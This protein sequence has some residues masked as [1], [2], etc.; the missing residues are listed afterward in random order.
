MYLPNDSRYE[1]SVTSLTYRKAGGSGLTL[2]AV[3]LGLWQNFGDDTALE[4]Q[5]QLLF[6]A[7]DAGVTHFDL[8]NNYGPPAGSSEENFGKIITTDLAPYRDELLISS[9]AGYPMWPGPYGDGG[10]RKYLLSSLDQSLKRMKLDY[11]DIFYSHRYDSTTP[12]H[13]TL[14]ALKTAVDSGRALYAGISSYSATRTAQA[15]EVAKEIGLT[16][17]LHQPS[18]SLLNR[19]IEKPDA[20]GR[21]VTEVAND[22][23]MG[24]IAFSPLAQGLLSTKYLGGIPEDSRAARGGSFKKEHVSEQNIETLKKLNTIAQD[25]GQSLTQMAIA[26]CLRSDQITSVL[27]GARTLDQLEEN[28]GSLKNT[29]FSS[30]ELAEIDRVAVDGDLNLWAPRSSEL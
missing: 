20:S 19:W 9:K 3:T 5:K 7:F 14:G 25:R 21:S 18:Y 13:E 10:S 23:G 6:S 1:Q 12:L 24:I 11:V 16:L 26:W 8:A 27:L 30:D 28:L 2:P 29:S 4:T 15:L 22:G 17:V